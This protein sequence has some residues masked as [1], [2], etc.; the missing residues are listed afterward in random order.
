VFVRK[1]ATY[2]N[3][4]AADSVFLPESGDRMHVQVPE[5]MVADILLRG[6]R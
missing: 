1:M 3:L 2:Y 4:L 6:T 5:Y